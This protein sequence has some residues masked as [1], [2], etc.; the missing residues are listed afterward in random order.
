MKRLKG[1]EVELPP[2]LNLR[3]K[4]DVN[5]TEALS[6]K[7]LGNRFLTHVPQASPKAAE[8]MGRGLTSPIFLV[9]EAPFQPNIGIAVPAA[10]A[11]GTDARNRAEAAGEPFGNIFTTTAGK[12]DDRDGAYVYSVLQK[13]FIWTEKLFDC[14]NYEAFKKLVCT[15][16][17]FPTIPYINLTFDHLQLDKDDEWLRKAIDNAAN[18]VTGK[19]GL[20][21]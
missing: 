12:K 9:D 14:E 1:I 6:V 16:S 10:F 20:I 7:A 4:L 17:G 11:A 2:Y 15:N 18:I 8:K 21:S 5:N 19:Q 13:C 3:S